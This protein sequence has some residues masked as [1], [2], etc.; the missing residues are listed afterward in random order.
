M[1]IPVRLPDLEHW[2]AQV[3]CQA[4]CPVATDAGRYVQLIAEG[5]DEDAYPRRAGPQPVRLGLRPGLRGALRGRLPARRDR[6]PD[7]DPRAQA[8]RHRALR[9]RVGPARHPGPAARASW[10]PRATATPATSP[11]RRSRRAARPAASRRRVAV[12]GAGPAGLAAAHDLA[13]LGYD[14]TVFEAAEEPG[15]MMRFGIPEYRLPRTL[16][17]AEIDKIVGARRDDPAEDAALAG[18]RPG[19]A[20]ARGV[21][22]RLPL[23][24]RLDR[25]A[26]SR[27]PGVELDGVVKA[28]DYLLNVNRGYRMDLGRRVVVIGGGFVAFD[29]ARTALRIGQPRPATS[30]SCWPAET[31][32]RDEG[33]ARLGARGAPRRRA[34]GDDRLARELRRDARAQDDAGARGVR[35]GAAAR[36]SS[37]CRGAARGAS[38]A[39]AACGDRAAR[40]ALG[41]RRER[42]LRADLRRRRPGHDRGRRLRPGDRPAAGPV[43]P[44]ARGRGRADAR[45]HDQ[46]RPGDARDLGARRLRRRRRRLRAA[47]PDRGGGERQ[48]GGALDPRAP[49]PRER[50]ARKSCWRSR[51]SRPRATGC[52]PGSRSSTARRRRRS[53]SAAAPGSPRSR[54]ATTRPRPRARP[55]AAWSA[56]S[57]RSTTPRSACSATAAWT[58][59]R[60]TAWRSSPS[61][62]STCRRRAGAA[63]GPRRGERAPA[64]RDDQGRRALHPLRPLR[65]PLPDRRDDDGAVPDHRALRVRRRT[66]G[67]TMSDQEKQNDRRDFLLKLGIGARVRRDRHAGRRL[68]PLAGAERLL[69]RP[70]DR[71]AGAARRLP[72]RP[73]VPARRAAL[74]VPRGERLP[75]DLGGLHAPRLHGAGRGAVAAREPGGRGAPLRL[76]HRFLCP[77]H[78]SKYTGDGGNVSGPAPRPL[79]WYHLSV[80]PDDGQLV[81]DLAQEVG[82]DF[83]LTVA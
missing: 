23:G 74:R 66:R 35:G 57:R 82:H 36:G 64:V 11:S 68:A 55:R 15:G 75:R 48:A 42:A 50:A 12:I 25:A 7:R 70:D 16:I 53:T 6:R 45:R 17:R 28:V 76:T 34:R 27:C 73:E 1:T 51:S 9:R 65:H 43:V 60:S 71:E 54:P 39:T 2:K 31:D 32:A 4:G 58:S 67:E 22:G 63:A 5:R 79:A 78:G 20:P 10:W 83:R 46:G 72:G 13:L 56:T 26:T 69:R 62:S 21:R 49:R 18:L 19:A 37:S 14:V 8:L 47:Q 33:G 24:R 38:S 80:A 29:A 59:A 30:T 81:V 3:K 61:T 77:C 44:E 40:R 41:L 52:W